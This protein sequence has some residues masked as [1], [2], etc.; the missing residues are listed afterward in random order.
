MNHIQNQHFPIL[1]TN[2]LQKLEQLAFLP[3]PQVEKDRL[4]DK[5]K[6]L[7]QPSQE[8][9]YPRFQLNQEHLQQHSNSNTMWQRTSHQQ[10][11]NYLPNPL[12]IRQ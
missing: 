2:Q 4:V 6:T 3:T 11:I 1:S 7:N 9:D 10:S 12:K 8:N 5:F